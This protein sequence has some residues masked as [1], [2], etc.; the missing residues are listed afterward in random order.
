MI[1]IELKEQQIAEAFAMLERNLTD[2]SELMNEVGDT[3]RISTKDRMAAGISPDGQP[4]APRS[5]TT[6]AIYQH[7]QQKFGPHPLWM[8][9]HMR[10]QIDHSYGPDHA[11]IGSVAIQAALLQFGAPKGAFGKGKTGRSNPWGNI[12]A[13]PFLGVSQQ[14]R[15]NLLEIMA[16]WLE[17]ASPSP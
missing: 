2:M 17:R 1:E 11:E 12:P 7:R 10:S 9:G 4:F 8:N 13:R 6:L 16:E 15:S 3:L 5:P 14:D